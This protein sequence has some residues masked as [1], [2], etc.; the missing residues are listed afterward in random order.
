VKVKDFLVDE[1]S[2]SAILESG[3]T[4][5]AKLIVGADGRN[6][7][8]REWMDVPVRTRNYKQRAIV[9]TA[10]HENPHD[11]IAVEH[12]RPEGPFAILPMADA[13]DG[14]HRSSV[15][16]TEHGPEKNSFMRL[17]DADFNAELNRRFPRKLRAGGI[18]RPPGVA[19]SKPC[20]CGQ[21]HSPP[22]GPD[23]RCGPR[24]PSRGRA[25][26]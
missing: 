13:A 17:S 15:V 9:F 11:N 12:F 7:F 8:T 10:A 5:T 22:D 14:T 23:C 26:A 2:A 21:L 24:H 20:P 6:S 16:F 25:G 3:E 4:V 19:P 1:N 18:D